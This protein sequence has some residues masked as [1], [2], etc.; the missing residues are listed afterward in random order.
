MRSSTPSRTFAPAKNLQPAV[1]EGLDFDLGTGDEAEA[2]GEA[3]AGASLDFDLGLDDSGEGGLDISLDDLAAAAPP[4]PEEALGLDLTLDDGT[5][6]DRTSGEESVVD[7]TADD[8]SLDFVLDDAPAASDTASELGQTGLETLGADETAFNDDATTMEFLPLTP[9]DTQAKQAAANVAFLPG[10][11]VDGE[12]TDG[13][14]WKCCRSVR[15][16]P[17]VMSHPMI[18][19]GRMAP[20]LMMWCRWTTLAKMPV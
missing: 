17:Q 14:R 10:A 13:I 3:T 1:D 2:V 20:Q 11:M 4:E 18:L 7:A 16:T 8:M 15:T 5:A 19:L 12:T 9:E 6:T